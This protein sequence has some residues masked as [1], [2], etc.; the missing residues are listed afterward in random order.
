[1]TIETKY[2]IGDEVWVII[3]NEVQ[4]LRI[5]ECKVSTARATRSEYGKFQVIEYRIVYYFGDGEWVSES[6][7]FPTKEEL[8]KSL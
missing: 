8:L 5:Q 2:D 6:K 1:M 7:C 4:K 3:E